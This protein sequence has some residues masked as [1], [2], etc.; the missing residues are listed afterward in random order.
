MNWQHILSFVLESGSGCIIINIS[1]AKQIMF[2]CVQAQLS[3][4][5]AL[6]LKCF[7][8]DFVELLGTLKTPVKCNDC[9]IPIAKI[10]VVADG[11]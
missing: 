7:S 4:K 6:E 8:N 5:R 1:L 2:N 11:F 3:E 9:K 10:A